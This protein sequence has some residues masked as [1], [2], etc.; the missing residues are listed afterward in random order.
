M[1]SLDEGG[2]YG[3]TGCL[4]SCSKDEVKVAEATEMATVNNAQE[5][6]RTPK[7]GRFESGLLY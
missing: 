7:I 3:L 1:A 4:S 6:G 5:V 2:I